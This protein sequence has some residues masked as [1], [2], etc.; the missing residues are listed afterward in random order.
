[1]STRQQRQQALARAIQERFRP[2]GAPSR[3]ALARPGT[4]SLA[5]WFLGPKSENQ[6]EMQRLLDLAFE[7][8]CQFRRDFQPDD[9]PYVTDGMKASQ[10]FRASLAELEAGLGELL[11]EMRA[12][13]PLSSYRN[14]S[15]MYWDIT[16]P[17]VLG[18]FGAMLYNQNNVAAEASPVTTFLEMEVGDDLC[19]MLGFALPPPNAPAG[20][21]RPWG[22]I[23]CDGSVANAESMWAARNLKFY[24]VS[25]AQALRHE[26]ALAKARGLTVST[27]DGRER[28]L[29]DL[30]TWELL[31]LRVDDVL[32]LAPRILALGIQPPALDDALSSYL[33]QDL[34][35]APFSARFL[36]D[37]AA[38]AVLAPCTAHYSWPKA[39]ALLGLGR[40]TVRSV[41]VDLDCRMD[42]GA[43]RAQ[44]EA[45]LEAK[46]PVLQV[47]AVIGTTEESA[48]DPL[49]AILDLRE[50]LRGRGLDFVLHVD[51]AWGGYF[52]A[53]LRDEAPTAGDAEDTPVQAM[54]AYVRAQFE[55]LGE[56]DSIT[57]DPHKGG[58]CPYPAGALC[59]RNGAMRNLVSFT[60]PVVYHGGVDPTVGV[61]GIEGSKPGAAA[62]GVYLSHR[63]IRT[64]RSG[65][66]RLLGQC[67]WNSKRLYAALLAL[68]QAGDPFFVET[69]Q[70]M[71]A[72]RRGAAEN[73]P[74][75]KIAE[76]LG[77]EMRIVRERIVPKTNAQL[78]KDEEALALL[79]EMGSDLNIV[80]YAFNFVHADGRRNTD[81]KHANALND[82]IYRKLSIG[83]KSA[84]E[85]IHPGAVKVPTNPMIVTDSALPLDPYGREFLLQ[86]AGRLGLSAAS[87]E[88]VARDGLTF[89]VST[90]QD[91]WVTETADGNLLPR[92]MDGLRQVVLDCVGHVRRAVANA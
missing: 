91:P 87:V 10:A 25:V 44:L 76:E 56:V 45:C 3:L 80:S 52:A 57:V 90:T 7:R 4:R 26:P 9:P 12:S 27:C 83:F 75:Q 2:E 19:R 89:L 38:P 86:F 43:L 81:A 5:A 32:A 30:G 29:A 46:Q 55:R 11:E 23:T 48:I 42:V 21:T 69:L 54:S 22:H 41:H 14:Q 61:Y 68:P 51:A 50:E 33:L 88:A 79:V 15:H 1:M 53:M 77:R 66:G 78:M 70:R 8:H 92:I 18:Y 34:G 24:A 63:V 16:M 31:N 37:V 71:P 64:D 82:A 72:L 20:T 35:L 65:Y 85:V 40:D 59:Y 47:V 36:A 62:A 13:V 84:G 74:A 39:A 67:I 58:F 17:S 28:P 6:A 60:A 73:W 49:A